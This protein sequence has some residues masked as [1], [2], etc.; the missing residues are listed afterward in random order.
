MSHLIDQKI[1]NE[2]DGEIISD[3]LAGYVF[4]ITGGIDKDGFAMK[5]GVLTQERKRL[6]LRKGSKGIRFRRNFHRAGTRIRKLVR[7]CIVSSDIRMLHIKVVKAGEKQIAG[8]NDVEALPRRLGPKVANNI[9]KELGLLDVYAK[10]KQNP[11]ERGTLRYMITKFVNKREVKTKNG[12]VY[13]KSPKVQRLITPLRLRR[14]RLLKKAKKEA[15]QNTEN[16]KKNYEETY[17]RAKNSKK[18]KATTKKT[19][20]TTKA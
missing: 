9:L 3:S 12:K 10:M 8:L 15:V 4:K 2:F 20:K 6:L 17:K 5:N 14:K 1:G 16:Q 19:T 18:N 7:G 11:E 13:T